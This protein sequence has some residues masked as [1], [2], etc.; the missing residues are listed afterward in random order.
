MELGLS[1][2]WYRWGNGVDL[3]TTKSM[4]FAETMNIH[5]LCELNYFA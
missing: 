3:K 1:Q 5:N 2:L 4:Q